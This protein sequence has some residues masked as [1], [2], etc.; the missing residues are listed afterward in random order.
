MPAAA[1]PS[2]ATWRFD[3]IAA[4]ER[5]RVPALEAAGTPIEIIASVSGALAVA[6]S[7]TDA[8]FGRERKKDRAA[9][10]RAVVQ[11][12]VG[13][14]L[15]D[16]FFNAR[17]GYRAHFRADYKTGLH[18]NAEIMIAVRRQLELSLLEMVA[19][20]DLNESFKDIGPAAIQ[21]NFIIA[22]LDPELGKIWYCSDRLSLDGKIQILAPGITGPGLEIDD[23]DTWPAPYRD[24][25]DAW[26]QVTGAFRDEAG[27]WY[28]G[29]DPVCRAKRLQRDGTA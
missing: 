9:D 2:P 23:S 13:A 26:L 22:S 7:K 10:C 19:G 15:F 27:R 8:R 4:C 29:K 12:A 18:F 16:R 24:D 6:L 1:L 28:A 17:T 20:R 5:H 3:R 14:P 11:F 21:K 25:E